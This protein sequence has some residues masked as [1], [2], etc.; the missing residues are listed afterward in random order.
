M[1]S[2]DNNM[3]QGSQSQQEC[4]PTSSGLKMFIQR[5]RRW[6]IIRRGRSRT[7]DGI[8][9]NDWTREIADGGADGALVATEPT[10]SGDVGSVG[11]FYRSKHRE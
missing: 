11:F 5:V 1:P 4:V 9:G 10:D 7:T 2:I 6:C 3:G 8:E